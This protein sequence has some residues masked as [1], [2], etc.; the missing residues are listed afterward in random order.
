MR[1]DM[2]TAICADSLSEPGSVG[3]VRGRHR[4][5]GRHRSTGPTALRAGIRRHFMLLVVFSLTASVLAAMS[6]S[7]LASSASSRVV[8]GLVVLY[9]FGEGS[10]SLVADTSGFGTPLD[11]SVQD[12]TRVSWGPE[13]LTVNASTMIAST[14]PATKIIDAVQATDEISV[15]AW[16]DPAN[17]TQ[18][19]PAR[20]VTLSLDLYNRNMTLGQGVWATTGDRIEARLRT[21][22]TDASGH[23]APRTAPGTLPDRLVHIVYTRDAT[24]TANVYLDGTLTAS[25]IVTGDFSNWDPTYRFALANEFTGNR[26]WL[27][28]YC[29]VALYDHALTP[30]E[31]TQNHNAGCSVP[32]GPDDV[33]PVVEPDQAFAA[34]GDAALGTA[35]ATIQASD[36]VGVTGFSITG[37]NGAGSFDVGT[38]GTITVMAT[39]DFDNIPVYTLIVNASDAAGN[40]SAPEAVTIVEAVPLWTHY[41]S[42]TGEIPTPIT[43]PAQTAS[44]IL[45]V[46]NDGD[47]DFVI[48]ARPPAPS[49][50]WYE[51]S[52]AGWQQHVIDAGA[53]MIEAGGAF[54]DIDGDGDLDIVM[55]GDVPDSEVWW[56]ENPYPS[57]N[58]GGW[59]KR[60]LASSPSFTYLHDQTFGDFD[61][62]GALEVAF[63]DQ[64]GRKLQL[65]DIPVDPRATEPWPYAQIYSYTGTAHY[66]LTTADIDLDGKADIVGGGMWFKHNGGTSYTA[67]VID[68]SPN[69]RVAVGQLIPGGRPE[70]VTVEHQGAGR[71]RWH[72]W[73]GTAWQEHTLL[74]GPTDVHSLDVGDVN[75]DGNLDIFSAEMRIGGGNPGARMWVLLG[76]GAGRFATTIV[77]TGLGNHESR[78]GDLDGDGDL[79][80][81]GKPFNWDTP[82]VDLWFT[83]GTPAFNVPPTPDIAA[84]PTTG[85]AP[86]TV[87][88][89]GRGST[90]DGA[91]V[92]Y[93]WDFGDGSGNNGAQTSH[94]YD[95]PGVFVARLTVT[96]D[97]GVSSS[98]N[99]DITVV[100]PDVDPPVISGI[101]ASPV[102]AAARITWATDEPATSRL[103]WGPAAGVYT[104]GSV[105]DALLTLS[106]TLD[107]TGLTPGTTYHY[108]VISADTSGNTAASDDRI[109]TTSPDSAPVIDIWYGPS[110]RFGQLGLPQVWVDVLGNVQDPDGIASLT[111]SLN[112]GADQAMSMGP[113]T[114]RLLMPGDFDAQIATSALME[115]DNTVVVTAVDSGGATA[116]A[117]VTVNWTEGVTWP[118]PYTINWSTVAAIQDVAQIVDGKW[119]LTPQGVRPIE[120]GYDRLVDIGD[121]SW[122][123]YEITVPVTVNALDTGYDW[124]QGP[125]FGPAVGVLL[126]WDG[127]DD[128]DGTQPTWG[129]WPMGSFGMH[130]WTAGGEEALQIMGN[131]G[132]LEAEDT[133]RTMAIGDTYVYKMRVE[134]NSLGAR[135]SLKVWN[136]SVPEPAGWDLTDQEGLSDPQTG[137]VLLV[138]HHVNATFGNVAIFPIVDNDPPIIG[139]LAE[140]TTETSATVTWTTDEPADSRL[141]WGPAAGV[142]TDGSSA[143]ATLTTAHSLQA[144]GL[145]PAT[146][147]HYQ[148][149]STDASGN[150]STSSDRTFTTQ[151]SG[152]DPSGIVSDEFSGAALDT[153]VWSAVDPVGDG[154]VTVTG[155]RLELTV[156]AGPA[157]DPWSNGN[158]SLRVMQAAN[159]TDFEIAVKFDSSVTATYQGQGMLVEESPTRFLRFDLYSYAGDVYAYSAFIDGNSVTTELNTTASLGAPMWLRVGRSGDTWTYSA[160]S[161]GSTWTDLTSYTQSITVTSVG[162]FSGNFPDGTAPEHTALVDRFLNT[163]TTV[164]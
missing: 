34:P 41:S 158:T 116:T 94:I 112:G 145:D 23:P 160:S 93:D 49:M 6:P 141:E 130:R 143:D 52:S 82:R 102:S 51:R 156:G 106:H 134:S 81:L 32:A 80:I 140:S 79:D 154:S 21:T 73:D 85:T 77:A 107:A 27:G 162:V 48:A 12:P 54:S 125:S 78:L 87:T 53:T 38:D 11:L 139:S 90:D 111:F 110:Q 68:P 15:E 59:T 155:G 132:T 44:L 117:R 72:G 29:L 157:H 57:Y 9:E 19:G 5:R 58:A 17:L 40:V 129:W 99:V 136:D 35:V 16:V 65:A 13:G 63:W 45:D 36:N 60:V 142:Y 164:P 121:V 95:V 113:N 137:S 103:E 62:D 163:A 144:S 127:H 114:R 124:S 24:G 105:E 71:L 56:W 148:V 31:I 138:A 131:E 153:T 115:G 84:D 20:I 101:A 55:G 30:T 37:G 25:R 98:A 89:D 159:D 42:A 108:R 46:D 120:I 26:P 43:S 4:H 3:R 2:H 86:L 39:L 28:T 126:R 18:N 147:Y 128:W 122:S 161:D 91:I 8:D 92:S 146:T 88:F 104:L 135:Y 74:G 10:G 1:I 76:D 61:G 22:N 64:G 100:A 109:F 150:S 67:N 47:L 69:L 83:S 50:V 97:L 123:D 14:E 133:S 118:L 7:T 119:Q 33:S 151:P 149:I 66:G 96:D 70:V 152:G 75:G